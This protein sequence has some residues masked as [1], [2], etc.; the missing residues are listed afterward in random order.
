MTVDTAGVTTIRF[1]NFESTNTF[2]AE[3]VGTYRIKDRFSSFVN[4]SLYQFDLD[5]SNVEAELSNNAFGWYMHGNATL[6]MLPGFDVQTGLYYRGPV[7]I[8]R[9]KID[10][11]YQVS[12]ALKKTLFNDKASLTLNV[13]DVFNTMNFNFYKD[14]PTYFTDV[15]WTWTSQ[16]ASLTFSYN[17]GQADQRQRRRRQ[18][19][20]QSG[21]GGGGP[22]V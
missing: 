11:Q 21:G 6:T 10:E 22:G 1:E 20:Q 2:G 16:Q 17:F 4:V 9:G 12:F 15:G 18:P 7:N 8:S 5:G 14:D 13:N 3:I 19:A